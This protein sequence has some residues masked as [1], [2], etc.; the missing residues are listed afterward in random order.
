MPGFP[1]HHQL[2]ELAQ[3]HGL[4]SVDQ[5]LVMWTHLIARE[6]GYGLPRWLSCKESACNLGDTGVAGSVPEWGRS[7]RGGNGNPLQYSCLKNPMDREA[8]W[9]T[10]HAVTE[11]DTTEHENTFIHLA[12]ASLST[13][14]GVWSTGGRGEPR[15]EGAGCGGRAP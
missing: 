9:A 12:Q 4:A 5:N 15:M 13:T 6:A 2:P 14:V 1:V 8:W 3:T 7:P 10:V 11:S